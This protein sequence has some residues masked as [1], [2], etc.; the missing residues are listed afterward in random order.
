MKSFK[1]YITEAGKLYR[2]DDKKLIPKAQTYA[3]SPDDTG[4]G[5]VKNNVGWIPP[6]SWE[7]KKGLFAGHY[8]NVLAYAVPRATRWVVTGR[9]TKD[10]KPTIHFSESD[11][12]AIMSHKPTV[13]QYNVRQGFKKSQDGIEYFVQGDKAP[14]PI[15]QKTIKNPLEHIQKHYDVK[16]VPDLD[17]HK[18]GLEV[19][20]I[21]HNFEGEFEEK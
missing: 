6:E 20:G 18:R 16:F 15:S 9:R 21:G 2:F 10:T 7:R 17:S 11:R 4:S 3:F 19:R 13:S 12:E 8:H 5:N 14:S 1:Q